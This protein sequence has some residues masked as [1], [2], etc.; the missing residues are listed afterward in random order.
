MLI[1]HWTFP[2]RFQC[3][4]CAGDP[5]LELHGPDTFATITNDDGEI[6]R[7]G[8]PILAKGFS[9]TTNANQPSTRR[10]IR[11]IHG[12]GQRPAWRDGRRLVEVYE[13]D[14]EPVSKL[15]NIS[16]RAF[17]DT[18]D[19]IVIA[20]LILS[21]GTGDEQDCSR[22]IGPSWPP[23]VC[24]ARSPT[25]LELRDSSGALLFANNDWQDDR[26]KLRK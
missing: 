17:V 23:L 11:S 4:G 12:C 25:N 15:A 9:P 16:T 14:E 2:V 24:L 8:G 6:P 13:V 5:V 1:G 21:N 19:N 26:I 22:G 18:G 3:S 10:W 20:G 7:A